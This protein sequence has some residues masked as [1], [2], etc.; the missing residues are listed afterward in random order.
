MIPSIATIYPMPHRH[1]AYLYNG[2]VV[3]QE[4]IDGSQFSFALDGE[5]GVSMRSK[6]AALHLASPEK[7]FRAGMDYVLRLGHLLRPGWTYRAEYLVKPKHNALAY[8]RVP[9]NHLILFDAED[10]AGNFLEPVALQAE[11]ER[12]GLEAVPML[13]IGHVNPMTKWE[14]YLTTTSC[15]GGQKI[16][17]VVIKN[18]AEMDPGSKRFPLMAKLVSADFKEV[19]AK[20]WKA[21]NPNAADIIISLQKALATPARWRKAV[22][23]LEEQGK[24]T[25][26]VQDIG[27]LMAEVRADITKE[28]ADEITAKL[29]A[30]AMP[31][32]LRGA[33]HGLPE[34]WKAEISRAGS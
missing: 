4:K 5:T 33:A 9:V 30:W 17:G 8:N 27:P 3:V 2:P 11:A 28:C 31:K 32:I 25:N 16:E 21:S 15:L 12:L 1:L 19:H 26:S 29:V 6:G 22:I 18:Y 14:S 13:F 10:E 24:L 34:W 20:E 7:M 23:H